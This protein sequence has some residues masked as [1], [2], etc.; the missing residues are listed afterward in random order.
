MIDV[1]PDVEPLP[2]HPENVIGWGWSR[3]FTRIKHIAP[4]IW[5]LDIDMGLPND[6]NRRFLLA[7]SAL[8]LLRKEEKRLFQLPDA[9]ISL[10]AE[11][12]RKLERSQS[13]KLSP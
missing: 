4:E 5:R 1:L 12:Q 9:E 6:E 11:E 2:P 8:N 7:R 3:D 13:V 10:L